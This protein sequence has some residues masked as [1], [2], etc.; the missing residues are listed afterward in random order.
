[1]Y[2]LTMIFVMVKK[3]VFIVVFIIAGMAVAGR[4]PAKAQQYGVTAH[5]GKYGIYISCG[6]EIPRDFAYRIERSPAGKEQWQ[7]VGS[8]LF[9]NDSVLFFN[10]LVAA[11]AV[12]SSTVLPPRA[13]R[14]SLWHAVSR[15][16][17]AD[18]LGYYAGFL[19]FRQALGTVFLDTAVAAV[20]RYAYRVLK[21][22]NMV[23]ATQVTAFP[24][25]VADAGLRTVYALPQGREVTLRYHSSSHTPPVHLRLYRQTE[26]QT[27]FREVPATVRFVRDPGDGR[28]YFILTDSTAAQNVVYRYSAVPY[29]IAGNAGKPSDTVRLA[30][31]LADGAPLVHYFTAVGDTVQNAVRLSWQTAS[32]AHPPQGF[33]IYRAA[34]HNSQP[35]YIGTAA[36]SVFYD[37]DVLPGKAWYYRLVV[38]SAKGDSP[39]SGWIPG[40]LPAR[41]Q[42][43]AAAP[44]YPEAT[45]AAGAVHIRWTRPDQMT[46]GYYVYRSASRGDSLIQLSPFIDGREDMAAYTDSLP[47][48]MA[49]MLYYALRSV[50]VSDNLSPFSDTVS[51]RVLPAVIDVLPGWQPRITW[52]GHAVTLFWGHLQPEV[53]GIMALRVLRQDDEGGDFRDVSGE[54]TAATTFWQDS[55]YR[56][57]GRCRYRVDWAGADGSVRE[58]ITTMF[59][60]PSGRLYAPAGLLLRT[61]KQGVIL[62][63]DPSRQRA[64]TNYHILRRRR[65]TIEREQVGTVRAD[66]QLFSDSPTVPGYYYYAIVSVDADGRKSAIE[67]WVGIDVERP[68]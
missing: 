6:S 60:I 64:V 13:M 4:T 27:G 42:D 14:A 7:P 30:N 26:L 25:P 43:V 54:L 28:N 5:A 15:A 18:S 9:V 67:D 20:N 61:V 57:G 52:D 22:G 19:A 31:Q 37:M 11:A 47:P 29:D 53:T 40:L 65:G 36:D 45:A 24:A 59:H 32:S 63:W 56:E 1:M 41:R 2:G 49:G 44:L 34:D 3:Q 46:K 51:V 58:G 39:R 50:N 38:H 8:A 66:V 62:T 12:N 68:L 33:S 48:G 23:G 17:A 10:R 16:S 21:N 55:S 35:E